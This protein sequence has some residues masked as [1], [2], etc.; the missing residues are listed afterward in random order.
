MLNL[1]QYTLA[2]LADKLCCNV[3]LIKV[4]A[5]SHVGQ[6]SI[7]VCALLCSSALP[8]ALTGF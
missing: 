2:L 5:L 8:P 7:Q 4:A 1:L 3:P 6:V